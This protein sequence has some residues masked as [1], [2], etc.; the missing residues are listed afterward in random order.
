MNTLTKTTAFIYIRVSTPSQQVDEQIKIVKR[1]AEEYGIQIIG[2]YGDY[3][4]R[5]KSDKRRSFQAM[6]KDIE[7]IKPGMVL[8]QRLDRFGTADSNELGYFIHLLKTHGVRLVTAIDGRD[9]SRGDLETSLMNAIAACQ[10]KQEQIDK[11]ER[12]LTGKR[13]K[14]VSGEYIGSKHLVYG[15]DVICVGRDGHEKWRMV[16]DAWD[17]R[18]KYVLNEAGEYVETE[19]YGN[20]IDRDP[21]GIMPDKEV[22]HRPSKDSS[23]RLHYSPS[24]RQERVET[25]RRI[26]EMFDAGWTTYSIAKQLN[27]EGI[28]PVYA[29]YWYSTMIDGL[30]GNALLVGRPAWNRTSQSSFRHIE[31]GKVVETNEELKSKCRTNRPEE[32]YQPDEGIFE[33]VIPVAMFDRIQQ[34]LE[35][36][37]ATTP[38]RSPR[39]EQ[40]WFGGLWE[41]E[42]TGLKLTG[43]S[44]GK[45]FRVKHPDHHDKKLSFKQAEWFI[46]EYLT[47]IG[48]RLETLGQAAESKRLLESLCEQEWMTE[49]RLNYLVLQIEDYLEGRLEEG[50]NKIGNTKVILDYD[51]EGN[52]VVTTDGDYLEIYCQMVSDDMDTNRDRVAALMDERKRLTVELMQMRDKNQFIIDTYNERI[53]E[54][55]R[56]IEDA[57]SPPDFNAWW[58]AT[59]EEL[60]LLRE[61]QESVREAIEKGE[62]VEKANAIG[63]MID[64]IVCHWDKE[65]TSDGR[66]KS[67]FRTFCRAVTVH[68]TAAVVDNGQVAPIM[69][70]ETSTACSSSSFP[71]ASSSWERPRPRWT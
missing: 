51:D 66:H 46:S 48:E 14:A 61:R 59:Q 55:G 39:S 45:H 19:R 13:G 71:P 18:V 57:T 56:E 38:K 49:L 12:V 21:N 60:A 22:R 50:W 31:G 54:L 68:S 26:C 16:E 15:F 33:P 24:I 58:N 6:L 42:E 29:D 25:L 9:C 5:H 23:D 27:D 32:W 40:L 30:L 20:E 52:R 34:R 11:A 65:P 47:R 62:W 2:Q 67:G 63:R 44:Q 43:N 64:R 28:R 10:S 4:K 37:R 8:V 17:V 7:T 35:E 41:C 70:I 69:T 3:Q 53:G 1:F 36:R